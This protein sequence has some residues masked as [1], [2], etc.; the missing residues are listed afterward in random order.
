MT[1]DSRLNEWFVPKFGPLKF[2]LFIGLLF[3]PYTGMCI[4]FVVLGALLSPNLNFERLFSICLIYFM[5]LGIAGHVADNMGSKKIKPWGNLFSKNQSW[6]LI[7][8]CLVLSYLL[9][10][11][12]IVYFT[13]LL[14][15]VG[16][17]ESFSCLFI[18]LNYLMVFS[19]MIFGFHF[20]GVCCLFL[21]DLL[22]KPII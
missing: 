15:A 1:K 22:F 21:R 13:P 16:I 2:R 19:I 18:I 6:G 4:S 5:S 14:L 3:L 17:L 7:T 9:A 8:L 12:Y 11:Y 20:L 10:F